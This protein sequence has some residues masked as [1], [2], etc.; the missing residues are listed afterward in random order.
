MTKKTKPNLNERIV[1]FCIA[2]RIK[3]VDLEKAGYASKQTINQI[4]HNKRSPSSAFLERL[5][6]DNEDLNARWLLTGTGNMI[7]ND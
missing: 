7:I 1:L 3:Q 4:W 2:K 5:V 6:S